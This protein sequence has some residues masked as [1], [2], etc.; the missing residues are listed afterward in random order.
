MI[1]DFL[2][3]N[4]EYEQKIEELKTDNDEKKKEFEEHKAKCKNLYD[5]YM[6]LAEIRAPV[7]VKVNNVASC[8]LIH[9]APQR[10]MS[11]LFF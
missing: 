4:V 11:N 1:S 2:E 8:W 10:I 3:N 5:N 9:L 7:N 6:K